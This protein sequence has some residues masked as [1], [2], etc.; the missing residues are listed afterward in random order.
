MKKGS[1]EC[2]TL[3]F[4]GTSTGNVCVWDVDLGKRNEDAGI[5]ARKGVSTTAMSIVDDDDDSENDTNDG[6]ENSDKKNGTNETVAV[7][8]QKTGNW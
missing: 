5:K 2:S 8:F 3:L 7:V 1:G 4:I 6:S